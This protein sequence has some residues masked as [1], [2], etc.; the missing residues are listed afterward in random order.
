M[1]KFGTIGNVGTVFKSFIKNDYF[2]PYK[3]TFLMKILVKIIVKII[4]W[5]VKI[6]DKIIKSDKIYSNS[7]IIVKK[8]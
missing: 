6:T 7:Y 8:I 4:Y 2:S 1:I 5:I 3:K